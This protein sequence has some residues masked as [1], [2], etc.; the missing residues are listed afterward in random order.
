MMGH[1]RILLAAAVCATA[2]A[3]MQGWPLF[4]Q[5]GG[6]QPAQTQPAGGGAH[7]AGGVLSWQIG[8]ATLGG[9]YEP[10][11]SAAR[12]SNKPLLIMFGAPWCEWCRKLNEDMKSPEIQAEVAGFERLYVDFDANRE[13]AR[14]LGV[15]PIPALRIVRPTGRMQAVQDGY[16]PPGPLAAWLKEGKTGAAVVG[17]E[18]LLDEDTLSDETVTKLVGMFGDPEASVREA[19]LRR[20]LAHRA[21]AAAAVVKAL[22]DKALAV[23]LTAIDLLD[24]WKAPVEGIDPWRVETITKE[25]VSALEA[26]AS[27]PDAAAATAPALDEQRRA[28]ARD[29]IGRMLQAADE[30]V[31][32]VRE[33]LARY[34]TALLPDIYAALAAAGN[35]RD[36]Q[37]L[38][39]LRYRVAASDA[40]ALQWPAGLERL[41]S[42]QV[43]VRHSALEE[44]T[45]RAGARD[46]G[47][48]LELFSDPDALVRETALRLLQKTGA[49]SATDALANLLKDPDP[50]VRA[51][52]LKSVAESPSPQITAKIAAYLG[53][54]RDIDLVVH[55]AR[56]LRNADAPV[57]TKTLYTLLDHESWRVRAEATEALTEKPGTTAE[58]KAEFYARMLRLL[59]DADGFVASRALMAVETADGLP[60]LKEVAGAAEKHPELASLAVAVMANNLK[61]D[62]KGV[63]Y[64]RS[65]ATHKDAGVR[66]ATITGLAGAVGEGAADALQRALE[67]PDER[68]R[69]AA[70]R[71][72]FAQLK[73][74]WQTQ[75]ARAG[76]SPSGLGALLSVFGGGSGGGSGGGGTAGRRPAWLTA[77]RPELEKLMASPSKELSFRATLPLVGLGDTETAVPVLKERVKENP[78]SLE[79]ASEVLPFLPWEPR[80][81]LFDDLK[82]RSS[83]RS[84]SYLARGLSAD[85]D[86]RAAEPLWLLLE[87]REATWEILNYV[88]SPLRRV[89]LG[90]EYSDEVTPALK[91]S[92]TETLVK[93][94]SG[95]NERQKAL[96]LALLSAVDPVVTAEWTA[97]IIAD[98]KN[99]PE[100]RRDAFQIQLSMLSRPEGETAAVAALALDDPLRRQLALD[101][102]AIG[103]DA[104]RYLRQTIYLRGAVSY[105]DY[106]SGT[107]I[108]P[109]PPRG[110]KAE[111]VKP[112][113]SDANPRTAAIAGYLLA[114]FRD[115]SGLDKLLAY[116]R[117]NST[118]H[119]EVCRL[120]YRAIAALDDDALTPVLAEIYKTLS[121]SGTWNLREFYWTIRSMTGER[122]MALRKQMRDEVGME[123]L[124]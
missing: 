82:E 72:I 55:A 70:T 117:T 18:A 113:L 105:S 39:L 38:T 36:R 86:S 7:G 3:G 118:D 103:P 74:W 20:L 91:R 26:W 76:S 32:A 110:L 80:L 65:F 61:S 85:G 8:S 22:S 54:E 5:Q 99:T 66:A 52:V 64:L 10:A 19:A 42:P 71:A 106:S 93:R 14:K 119:D 107:P 4:A 50:N 56:V 88:E 81:A 96:A 28:E 98:P 46:T 17:L 120:V 37:R 108:A 87:H 69:I 35:D 114:L 13:L 27:R 63:D 58:Q 112:F 57:A 53:E 30:D 121:K 75:R 77:F 33:R 104:V 29:L 16:L 68:V 92:A 62:P 90:S 83:A 2:G 40:L 123:A 24:S 25:R 59:D 12:Q 60:S 49:A 111:Q 101:F 15:G 47:L 116:Y 94:I 122:C 97:K 67:D 115:R 34:G 102:L 21:K 109:V 44:L 79:D 11:L 43:K 51:A 124:R 45:S 41:A 89:L 95:G 23:R 6:T 84:L 1:R 78:N 31:A 9:G 73:T 48:L 100:L